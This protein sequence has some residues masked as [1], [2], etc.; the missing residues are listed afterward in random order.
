[1]YGVGIQEPA[2]RKSRQLQGKRHGPV[3]GL[4]YS[5]TPF[6]ASHSP[7]AHIVSSLADLRVHLSDHLV[8]RLQGVLV[9]LV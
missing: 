2:Q 6:R 3:H 8:C 5:T 9:H 4:P 7:A 1:M